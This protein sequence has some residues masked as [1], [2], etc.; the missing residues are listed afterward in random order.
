MNHPQF[1]VFLPDRLA[2]RDVIRSIEDALVD[3]RAR[4]EAVN[5]NGVGAL[6]LDRAAQSTAR[7]CLPQSDV[8]LMTEKQALSFNPASR[9]EY[10]GD[11]LTS[12]CRIASIALDDAMI[13]PHDANLRRMEFSERTGSNFRERQ[14]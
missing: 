11:E 13:L 4:H 7:R 14:R 8:E 9:L 6:D 3:L 10:V 1:A 2:G 12:K 5:L